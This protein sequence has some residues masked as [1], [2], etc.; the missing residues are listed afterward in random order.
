MKTLFVIAAFACVAMPRLAMASAVGCDTAIELAVAKQ[1]NETP[2]AEGLKFSKIND[3]TRSEEP[4]EQNI[5]D[6]GFS[7][8]EE[9]IGGARVTTKPAGLNSCSVESVDITGFD[10]G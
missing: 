2:P 3:I 9:C 7:Y 6:V 1:A 4:G 10:C 8:D 5:F